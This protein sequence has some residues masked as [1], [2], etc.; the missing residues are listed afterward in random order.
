MYQSSRLIGFCG[1]GMSFNIRRGTLDGVLVAPGLPR[2]A[3]MSPAYFVFP[4][5]AVFGAEQ[6]RDRMPEMHDLLA[7]PAGFEPATFSLEGCCSIP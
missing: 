5:G 4:P 7:T 2:L 3:G 1:P 6:R